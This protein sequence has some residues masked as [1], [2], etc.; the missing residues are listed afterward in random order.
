MIVYA[1]PAVLA[2]LSAITGLGAPAPWD[3]LRRRRTLAA[4]SARPRRRELVS[5]LAA[6]GTPL[7]V[8]PLSN[9]RLAVV[10]DLADHPIRAML[11]AGLNRITSYNVC[12]TKL[13]RAR[14]PA[15]QRL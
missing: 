3:E 15:V 6:S 11:E 4:F 12:Y 13:L 14:R 8:C 5:R 9:L 2:L 1:P 7:T 10:K